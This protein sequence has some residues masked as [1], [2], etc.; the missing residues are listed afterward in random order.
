VQTLKTSA[1][2]DERL[3]LL[4]GLIGNTLEDGSSALEVIRAG[5]LPVLWAQCSDSSDQEV[6]AAIR[7]QRAARPTNPSTCRQRCWA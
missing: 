6:L 5:A 3:R 7:R 1:D 4:K 2:R